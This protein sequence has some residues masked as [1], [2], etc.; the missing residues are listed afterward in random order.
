[1]EN[2]IAAAERDYM[3]R[4]FSRSGVDM[5]Y[6]VGNTISNS[7]LPGYQQGVMAKAGG[8]PWPDKE[9]RMLNQQRRQTKKAQKLFEKASKKAK[10][11]GG[12][13]LDYMR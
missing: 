1:M 12:S 5:G 11:K 3:D 6:N 7:Y 13:A 8:W 9:A 4:A 2:N 10:R